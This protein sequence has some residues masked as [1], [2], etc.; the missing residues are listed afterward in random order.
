[1]ADYF[2]ENPKENTIGYKADNT[3]FFLLKRPLYGLKQSPRNW[4][5]TVKTIFS[6]M[7][8]FPIISD[9]STYYNKELNI[10]IITYVDDFLIFG[11]KIKDINTVQNNLSKY[12]KITDLGPISYFLGIQIIRDRP[13]RKIQIH[14]STYI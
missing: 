9:E 5:N 2:R 3:Q 12:F 14:Q 8:F 1:M 6:K 13:A 7:G 11:L 10:F 4:Q